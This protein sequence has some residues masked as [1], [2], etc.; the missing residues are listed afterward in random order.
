VILESIQV[1]FLHL[2][3]VLGLILNIQPM[4]LVLVIG[5]P[6]AKVRLEPLQQLAKIAITRLS[7][8][9]LTVG[10]LQL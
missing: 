2:Q 6:A 4:L 5:L 1:L 7:I 9:A 3:G 10:M 8:I